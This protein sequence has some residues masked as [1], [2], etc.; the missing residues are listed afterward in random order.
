MLTGFEKIV[1]ERIR[2][3]QR[4]GAF[5][6][7][8]GAGSPLP[9]DDLAGV[10]DDLRLAFR[11]LRSA[12]C[13]PP[14]IELKKEIDQIED[15]LAAMPDTEEKYR[16]LKRLNFLILKL[17]TL[18]GTSVSNEIPQHYTERLVGRLEASRSRRK[19][20]GETG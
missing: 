2:A 12:D 9:P 8:S 18:R 10:P 17:N 6:N 1:E 19:P 5:D 4:K 20:A 15:L 13:L 7:L 14:E 11:M 3:A 16:S